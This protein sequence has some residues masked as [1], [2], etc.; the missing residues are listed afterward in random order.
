[1]S[2]RL[3]AAVPTFTTRNC[4]KAVVVAG[5]TVFE[6]SNCDGKSTAN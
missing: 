5:G 4:P 1:M 3:N 2:A 6:I